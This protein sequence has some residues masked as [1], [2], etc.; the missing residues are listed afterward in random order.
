MI[1][2]AQPQISAK[3]AIARAVVYIPLCFGIKSLV[4]CVGPTEVSQIFTFVFIQIMTIDDLL[5]YDVDLLVERTKYRPIPR[6]AISLPRAWMFFCL[7]LVL[8]VFLAVT[9]LRPKS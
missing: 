3:D 6:G 8:G 5:D 7:Q 2:H 9:F 4:S 1:Y